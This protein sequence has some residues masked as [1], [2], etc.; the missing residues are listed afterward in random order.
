M[1]SHLRTIG[2]AKRA[3]IAFSVTADRVIIHGVFT[4]GRIT[5]PSCRKSYDRSTLSVRESVSGYN[6]FDERWAYAIVWCT[7]AIAFSKNRLDESLLH[8]QLGQWVGVMT[9]LTAYTRC[10]TRSEVKTLCDRN[11]LLKSCLSSQLEFQL[12]LMHCCYYLGD[13]FG[14]FRCRFVVVRLLGADNYLDHI[15]LLKP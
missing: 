11:N 7:G 15:I 2:Y 1:R 10:I 8:F 14:F 3:T 12:I 5:I 6:S 13:Y 4:G 9:F